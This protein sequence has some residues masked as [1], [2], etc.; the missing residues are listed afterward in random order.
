MGSE[1]ILWYFSKRG[2]VHDNRLSQLWESLRVG[3]RMIS[4]VSARVMCQ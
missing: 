4:I 2:D 3:E 1:P